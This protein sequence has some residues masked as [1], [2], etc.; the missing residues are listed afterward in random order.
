MSDA[1]IYSV[2]FWD[3]NAC[4]VCARPDRSGANSVTQFL[5]QSL[6]LLQQSADQSEKSCE[7]NLTAD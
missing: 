1:N 7:D 4:A 3:S 2:G 5:E 6:V